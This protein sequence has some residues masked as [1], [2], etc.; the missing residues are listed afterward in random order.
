MHAHLYAL[1]SLRI[2]QNTGKSSTAF[3][4][5][6]SL[7]S[8]DNVFSSLSARFITPDKLYS[9]RTYSPGSSNPILFCLNSVLIMPVSVEDSIRSTSHNSVAF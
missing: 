4:N 1:V 8:S 3:R 7:L 5:T 6:S 2:F 9:I